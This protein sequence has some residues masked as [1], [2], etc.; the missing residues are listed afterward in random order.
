VGWDT[1]GDNDATSLGISRATTND[2]LLPQLDA[3]FTYAEAQGFNN[4]GVH[5]GSTSVEPGLQHGQ[6][7][8]HWSVSER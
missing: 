2:D 7:K 5:D 3:M 8:D 6:P 4:H 1:H